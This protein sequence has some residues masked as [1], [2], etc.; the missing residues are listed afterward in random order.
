MCISINGEIGRRLA[1]YCESAGISMSHLVEQLIDE[2]ISG[3]REISPAALLRGR[4]GCWDRGDLAPP[5]PLV[6]PEREAI[7]HIAENRKLLERVWAAQPAVALSSSVAIDVSPVLA[8][9]IQDQVE[10]IRSTGAE[11][12]PGDLLDRAICRMLDSMAR[13][14]WCR[15]CLEAHEHCRCSRAAA[16]GR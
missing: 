8:E 14:P 13:V 4:V 11:A 3:E 7:D 1:A 5:V 15:T 16:R 2:V 12:T 6:V 9:A 10:R